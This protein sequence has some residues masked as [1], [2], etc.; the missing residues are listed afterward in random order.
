M[1]RAQRAA[2]LGLAPRGAGEAARVAATRVPAGAAGRARGAAARGRS[3]SPDRRDRGPTRR[4][5]P[6]APA[7][8]VPWGRAGCGGSVRERGSAGRRLARARRASRGRGHDGAPV[9]P[10]HTVPP[11][12][13]SGKAARA[14]RLR[15]QTSSRVE[16]L[17]PTPF[18]T[19]CAAAKVARPGPTLDP[20]RAR[21]CRSRRKRQ[22]GRRRPGSSPSGASMRRAFRELISPGTAAAV[23]AAK[24]EARNVII[25]IS[26]IL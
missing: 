3:R 21:T 26:Y 2:D 23:K 22:N 16:V 9:P 11:D 12:P 5:T 24:V 10:A 20:N 7:R 13:P 19:K 14:P 8:R 6:P 15:P 4:R 25:R 1:M 17:N 18:I